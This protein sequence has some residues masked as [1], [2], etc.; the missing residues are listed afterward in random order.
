MAGNPVTRKRVA[1]ILDLGPEGEEQIFV[2]L[3]SGMPIRQIGLQLGLGEHGHRSLYRWR[4]ASEARKHAWEQALE[5]RADF[6][7][8]ESLELADDVR[9]D[10]DAIR[11]AELQIKVRQW[12]AGVSNPKRYGK[13][14]SSRTTVNIEYLHLTAVEAFNAQ[15]QAEAKARLLAASDEADYEIFADEDSQDG[16]EDLL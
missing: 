10:P 11:K 7:A 9:E 13:E 15:K 3:A 4:D 14:S 2:W 16:Y 8:E 6:L 1:K 5:H 12:L